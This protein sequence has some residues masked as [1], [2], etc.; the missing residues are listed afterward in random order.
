MKFESVFLIFFS[1]SVYFFHCLLS[2]AYICHIAKIV[3][4]WMQTQ[5]TNSYA[6]QSHRKSSTWDKSLYAFHISMQWLWSIYLLLMLKNL[7]ICQLLYIVAFFHY[8]LILYWYSHMK[9]FLF[10]FLYTR[11]SP[12]PIVRQ[13]THLSPINLSGIRKLVVSSTDEIQLYERD[14]F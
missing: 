6:V 11:L 1:S 10:I 5:M 12:F 4:S 2:S 14:L 8:Y 7:R 13:M 9:N 3:I